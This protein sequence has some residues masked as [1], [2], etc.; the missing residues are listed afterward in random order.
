MTPSR[1]STALSTLPP[2]PAS[3][4]NSYKEFEQTEPSSGRLA[5]AIA[6]YPYSHRAA[7]LDITDNSVAAGASAIA[8]ELPAGESPKLV[9]TD[10]GAGIPPETLSEVLR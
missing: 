10:N 4:P 2:S 9:I 7:I 6:G 1:S 8:I 5:V 3:Q